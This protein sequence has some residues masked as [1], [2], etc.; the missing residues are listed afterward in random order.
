MMRYGFSGTWRSFTTAGGGPDGG[1]ARARAP[2]P[3]P[4]AVRTVELRIVTRMRRATCIVS[5]SLRKCVVRRCPTRQP[6]PERVRVV[7]QAPLLEDRQGHCP[8]AAFAPAG[9]Q[10]LL[11]QPR[12][13]FIGLGVGGDR[14]LEQLPLHGQPDRVRRRVALA[15]PPSPLRRIEGG[16]ELATNFAGARRVPIHAPRPGEGCGGWWRLGEVGGGCFV[17]ASTILRNLHNLHQPPTG[18]RSTMLHS[19]GY[20]GRGGLWYPRSSAATS[21]GTVVR[22]SSRT[23]QGASGRTV[24]TAFTYPLQVWQISILRVCSPASGVR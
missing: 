24:V 13:E 1:R 21:S 11:V 2:P 23:A 19:S 8:H 22:S 17:T 14:A 6:F 10:A 3:Q 5:P 7:G 9:G 20:P 18:P 16:E 4:T 15:P 12:L